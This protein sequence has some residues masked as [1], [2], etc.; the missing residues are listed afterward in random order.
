MQTP[1]GLRANEQLLHDVSSLPPDTGRLEKH[2]RIMP[3]PSSVLELDALRNQARPLRSRHNPAPGI[4]PLM[5][6]PA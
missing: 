6:V 5:P 3:D 2:I 1:S 4:V